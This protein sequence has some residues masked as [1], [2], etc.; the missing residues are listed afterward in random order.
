MFQSKEDSNCGIYAHREW[1]SRLC[2]SQVL[3]NS[4]NPPHW[5]LAAR[6]PLIVL[7]QAKL[8]HADKSAVG[9]PPENWPSPVQQ[10]REG[11]RKLC[12]ELSKAA[13]SCQPRCGGCF[14]NARDSPLGE[15]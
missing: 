6:P 10:Q 4:F 11:T 12:G 7:Q 2:L 8:I 3:R 15:R 9:S 13:A 14:S 5:H 1:N